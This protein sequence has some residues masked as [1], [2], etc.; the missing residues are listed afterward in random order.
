LF[1][2]GQKHVYNGDHTEEG[3]ESFLQGK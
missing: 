2:S 3:I 1:Q